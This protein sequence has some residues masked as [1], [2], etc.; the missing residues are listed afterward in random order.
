ML[1]SKAVQTEG[2]LRPLSL[3]YTCA[4]E[5][6]RA[7]RLLRCSW[8]WHAWRTLRTSRWTC[9]SRKWYG[10]STSHSTLAIQGDCS[11]PKQCCCLRRSCKHVTAPY[12]APLLANT[13]WDRKR[14]AESLCSA[15]S[16]TLTVCAGVA[17]LCCAHS[18]ASALEHRR[19]LGLHHS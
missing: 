10:P 5:A 9:R 3:Y 17:L 1:S 18:D 8:R 19:L 7:P 12:R 14:V 13:V 6:W 4:A 15:H 2:V 11:A 16:L